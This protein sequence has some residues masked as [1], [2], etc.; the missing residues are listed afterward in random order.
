LLNCWHIIGIIILQMIEA[1]RA[2]GHGS[3]TALP[4]RKGYEAA[5][6]QR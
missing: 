6:P 1:A 5:K 4:L 2:A 3:V